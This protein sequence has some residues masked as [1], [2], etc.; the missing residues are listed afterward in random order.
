MYAHIIKFLLRALA[1]YE[2]DRIAHAIHSI[3]RP[4]ALRYDDLL[5]DI[6]R[7]SRAITDSANIS[8]H[9]E[10]RDMHHELQS[11]TALVR[12]FREEV[13]QDQ[14]ITSSTLLDFRHALSEIQFTQVSTLI[15]NACNIDHKSS[16]QASF[17]LR[18]KHR[19]IA[20][21]FKCPPFWTSHEF[22]T[23][24]TSQLSSL[25]TVRAPFR[26]RSYVRDFCTNTIEQLRN[27]GVAVLWVLKPIEQTSFT[28]IDAI[29]SLIL[30]SLSLDLV[31]RTAL[32]LPFTVRRFLDAQL[33]HEYISLLESSL[34][35]VKLVYIMVE[36]GAMD[37][38][39]AVQCQKQF[40]KLSQ[41]LSEGSSSVR[42]K[43]MFLA[44]GPDIHYLG[45]DGSTLKIGRTSR[46][47]GA[48]IPLEPLPS[49][50]NHG[51]RRMHQLGAR[52][53]RA[54]RGAKGAVIT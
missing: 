31:S 33:D 47:K 51:S 50:A 6:R 1:W 15:S 21:K 29:K 43:I 36:G 32:S 53:F 38:V 34:Q 27:A 12:Q 2:E 48:K 46:R 17:L 24:N 19:Y 42:L 14:A 16:L 20:R 49:V 4:A 11:L 52:P 45:N 22:Q 9:A 40:E 13:I 44:Y 35:N 8:S 5:E 10:Q 37:P 26:D 7:A 23:W 54:R 3:T 30:Q 39:S 25:I 18:D 41:K 28:V